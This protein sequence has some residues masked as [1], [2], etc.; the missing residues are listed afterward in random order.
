MSLPLP[1]DLVQPAERARNAFNQVATA[2]WLA[3]HRGQLTR[4]EYES[5]ILAAHSMYE[6]VL[7]HPELAPEPPLQ[8]HGDALREELVRQA[9]RMLRRG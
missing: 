2:A 3:Y 7:A 1:P 4:A 9:V 8:H 6:L 5:G